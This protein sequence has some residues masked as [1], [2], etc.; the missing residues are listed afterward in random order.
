MKP[1]KSSQ[2]TLARLMALIAAIAGVLAVPRLHTRIEVEVAACLVAL[3]LAFILVTFLIEMF[4]GLRCPGCS[5][6]TLHRMARSSSH[7]R[8]SICRLRVKRSWFGPWLDASGPE[9]A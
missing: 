4:F 2:I 1:T 7:F 3:L 8:C 5:R 6:W 9:D